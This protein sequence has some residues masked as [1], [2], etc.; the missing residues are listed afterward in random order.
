MQ[1]L[2][3]NYYP[4]PIL[5]SFGPIDIHWYGFFM[6]T[7]ILTGLFVSFKL[8][9]LYKVKEETIL[10][11][12]FYL[13]IFGIIG[14]RIY[15]V[16]LEFPYYA[17]NLLDIFKIWQGGLAIHGGLIGGA[18]GLYFF[19]K[20]NKLSFI[21]LAS[22]ITPGLALGQ[23]LGRFGN[24]FNQEL[25]GLPTNSPWGI[26]ISIINR[27]ENYLN[28]THF[29]PTFFYESIGSLIIFI[30]LIF[31]HKKNMQKNELN[32]E[33]ITKNFTNIILIYLLLYSI[34][35][36]I[37]EYIRIDYTPT[38]FEVRWPQIISLIIII[39]CIFKFIKKES[40]S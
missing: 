15:D 20:K 6:V 33:K 24:Y 40:K 36:F 23:A 38:L 4:E 29:H 16:F 25:F 32:K 17:N 22:I 39:T 8:G 3:Y 9:Q 27:P 13:V 34:L 10:D 35:R 30:V 19:T 11:L 18:T 2:L 26:P 37:L 5:L 31:L 12:A 28:S 1:K 21:K 14:A 7:A